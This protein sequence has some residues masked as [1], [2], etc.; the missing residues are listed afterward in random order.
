MLNEG[1]YF[2]LASEVNR[3]KIGFSENIRQR[4][5]SLQSASPCLLR[6]IGVAEGGESLEAALHARFR[7]SQYM[8]EWFYYPKE[9]Q[10][11]LMDN[12]EMKHVDKDAAAFFRHLL[13]I[14]EPD[15]RAAIL[16]F[17]EQTG[18]P[19]ATVLDE[20]EELSTEFSTS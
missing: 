12:V 9:I 13:D 6:L 4:L 3:V 17:S 5:S 1:V 15:F 18:L 2:I 14:S 8:G 19:E 11:W 16:R 20:Y 10:S 7:T